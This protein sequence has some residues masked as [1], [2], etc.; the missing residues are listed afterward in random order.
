MKNY[1]N[2]YDKRYFVKSRRIK[3]NQA[4]IDSLKN[5]IMSLEPESL[6]DV[7]CGIGKLVK[8]LNDEGIYTVGCDFAH[9]LKYNYWRGDPHFMQADA[10]KLPFATDSFDIVFSSDFFEHVPED[11]IERVRKGMFRVSKR[12]VV[13][14]V[15]YE[16]KLT[17]RQSQYH[18]TNK[19]QEWWEKKLEG[20]M[21]I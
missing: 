3:L 2:L 18:V 12:L 14:R 16:A 1:S 13:A 9:T 10:R 4:N 15:A 19:P 6:L 21:L 17:K 11:D 8:D 20:V 5:V 7:G